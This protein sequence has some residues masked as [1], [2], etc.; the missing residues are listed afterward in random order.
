LLYQ[1]ILL[2]R[3]RGEVARLEEYA[4]RF[5]ELSPQLRE[6]FEVHQALESG[7]PFDT[8]PAEG[9]PVTTP[10]PGSPGLPDAPLVPGYEILGELGRGGMGV[11]YRAV[12]TSLR[13]PVALKML[14][15]GVLAGSDAVAR[16]RREAETVAR[17]RHPNV[18]HLY[19]IGAWDGRPYFS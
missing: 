19:E 14:R 1:E 2:R 15:E 6:H 16:F 3:E 7:S 9:G 10:S 4:F 11:V 12:Q 5:P 18:V 13:R 17:L 8:A